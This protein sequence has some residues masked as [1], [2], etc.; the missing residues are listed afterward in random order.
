MVSGVV[1]EDAIRMDT[2]KGGRGTCGKMI[3]KQ[4]EAWRAN[5]RR[6]DREGERGAP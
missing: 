4:K 3:R 1:R 2:V 6:T 5:G